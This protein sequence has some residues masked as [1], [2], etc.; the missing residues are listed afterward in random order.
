[1]GSGAAVDGFQVQVSPNRSAMSSPA[2]P[3][4]PAGDGP[5]LGQDGRAQFGVV[6]LA[7]SQFGS[8]LG[9]R[10]AVGAARPERE[11]GAGV[12]VFVR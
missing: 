5:G 2:F 11:P 12:R 8:G 10:G 9:G 1:M 4:G 7:V 3:A 6:G